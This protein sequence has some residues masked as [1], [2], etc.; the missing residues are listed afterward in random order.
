MCGEIGERID[1]G[2][3]LR[4]QLLSETTGYVPWIVET[5]LMYTAIVGCSFAQADFFLNRIP[6]WHHTDTAFN[7]ERT[8]V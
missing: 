8:P 6:S 4:I 7:L 3:P 5:S 1:V 2:S